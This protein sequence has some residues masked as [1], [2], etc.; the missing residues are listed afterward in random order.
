MPRMLNRDRIEEYFR[1][2]LG[3]GFREFV[4]LI[5]LLKGLYFRKLY[6]FRNIAEYF[7]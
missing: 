3:V 6:F 2:I 4:F 1:N 5:V 7:I